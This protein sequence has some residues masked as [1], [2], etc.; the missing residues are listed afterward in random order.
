MLTKIWFTAD[1]HYGH[2]N[3]LRFCS[4]PWDDINDHD[5][6][7]IANHN[8]LVKDGDITIH[9]GDFTLWKNTSGVYKKYIN[10]LNGNHIFL[11]GSHDYWLKPDTITIWEKLIQ[12]QY[13]VVCHYNMRTWARSHYNSWQLYGH[14]HGNL[15]PVG[16]QWDIGVDNNDYKPISFEQLKVIMD[17]RPDNFNL[18]RRN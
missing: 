8:A 17:K 9:A 3:I 14:S 12:K 2:R 4:R 11:K 5:E 10:R 7:L 6:A 16:K 13:V 18:I 15:E 1:E